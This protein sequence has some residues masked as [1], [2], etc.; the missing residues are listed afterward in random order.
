LFTAIGVRGCLLELA[1]GGGK[2]LKGVC[3]CVPFWLG[4]LAL[5]VD[6][7]RDRRIERKSGAT[8]PELLTSEGVGS[9]EASRNDRYWLV[10]EK[11]C[12]EF[13]DP[14]QYG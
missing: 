14:F 11:D 13:G 4:E 3:A 6:R 2:L 12:W 10:G 1:D 5:L 7:V 9:D 8:L